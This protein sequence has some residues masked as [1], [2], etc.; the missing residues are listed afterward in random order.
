LHYRNT[1]GLEERV[2]I[3]AARSTEIE[4]GQVLVLW[5][6]KADADLDEDDLNDFEDD[7]N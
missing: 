1:L 4:G 7:N 6:R 3:L 2:P 5:I